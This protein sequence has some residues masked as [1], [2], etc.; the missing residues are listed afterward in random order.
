M[1]FSL[2]HAGKDG[3]VWADRDPGA[4]PPYKACSS[5]HVPMQ[6]LLLLLLL[7]LRPSTRC[8]HLTHHGTLCSW[9]KA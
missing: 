7:L 6:L 5:S 9:S 8:T 3:V 2:V 4:F 1:G